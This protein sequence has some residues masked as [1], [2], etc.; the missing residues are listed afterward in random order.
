MTAC[1]NCRLLQHSP[2]LLRELRIPKYFCN[3]FLQRCAPASLY[4]ESWPSLFIGPRGSACG[5]HVGARAPP[6]ASED[7]LQHASSIRGF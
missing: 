1:R 6:P 3:D 7:P 2:E 5:L 4:R